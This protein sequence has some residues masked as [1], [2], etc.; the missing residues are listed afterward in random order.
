MGRQ[1]GFEFEKSIEAKKE[2]EEKFLWLIAARGRCRRANQRGQSVAPAGA[3]AG[4][5]EK[6]EKGE[7]SAA[8]MGGLPYRDAQ[9]QE[10]VGM[11]GITD[12]E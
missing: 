8:A 7:I 1:I 11:Q 3:A 10:D 4:E 12:G 6:R 2:N 5:R 9:M